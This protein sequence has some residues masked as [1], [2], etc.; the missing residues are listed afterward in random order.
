MWTFSTSSGS[1]AV[2]S[3]A[4]LGPAPHLAEVTSRTGKSMT[5]GDVRWFCPPL[6][7]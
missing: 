7:F 1:F 4:R 3:R 2:G 6:A 5:I